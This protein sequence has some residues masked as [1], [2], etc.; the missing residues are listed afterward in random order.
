MDRREPS[1]G[2]SAG[3][4]AHKVLRTPH[5]PLQLYTWLTC[6]TSPP[7]VYYFAIEDLPDLLYDIHDEC[8]VSAGPLDIQ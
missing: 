1:N 4:I 3:I 8:I 2:R 6:P 5:L 7:T